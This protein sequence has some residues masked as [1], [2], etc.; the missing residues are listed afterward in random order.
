MSFLIFAYNHRNSKSW[1]KI[2]LNTKVRHQVIKT[3]RNALWW[4]GNEMELADVSLTLRRWPSRHF[5]AGGDDFVRVVCSRLLCSSTW[6]VCDSTH[7]LHCTRTN[8]MSC[9]CPNRSYDTHARTHARTHTHTRLT[10]LCPE[11]PG[12]AGTRKVKP[13]WIL[14]KQ[15]TAS[16]NGISWAICKSALSSR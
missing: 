9:H 15:E 8:I 13:T 6:T 10:A 2:L 4:P 12:S 3:D 5:P 16:G 7:S 14:L 1:N 11:L